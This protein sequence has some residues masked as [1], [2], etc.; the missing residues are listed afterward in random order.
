MLISL[1]PKPPVLTLQH[2]PA[3]GY[4]CFMILLL[5]PATDLRS[6]RGRF[7]ISK[8]GIQPVATRMAVPRRQDLYLLAANERLRKRDHHPIDLGA[9]AAVTHLRVNRIGKVERRRVSRE[10]DDM[11]LRR[12]HVDPIVESRLLEALDNV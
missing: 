2:R 3:L 1:R 8:I 12:E 4:V 10:I 9:A 7:Q 5:E 11:T 6:R